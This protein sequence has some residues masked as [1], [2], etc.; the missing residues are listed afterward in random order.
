[1]INCAKCG[2]ENP[3]GRVFC[4]ACGEKLDLRDMSSQ[5]VV[6]MQKVGWLAKHWP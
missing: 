6:E 1:M 3:L 2:T 5:R 4:K